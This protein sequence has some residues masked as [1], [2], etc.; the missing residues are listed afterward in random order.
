MR[1]PIMGIPSSAARIDTNDKEANHFRAFRNSDLNEWSSQSH[2]AL[3]R[4]NN[5]DPRTN[6]HQRQATI[7]NHFTLSHHC[8]CKDLFP[9]H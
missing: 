5:I 8:C 1:A 7:T 2:T 4:T 3:L 9:A 6:E